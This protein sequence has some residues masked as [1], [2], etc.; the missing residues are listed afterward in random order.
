MRTGLLNSGHRISEVPP[1]AVLLNSDCCTSEI[2]LLMWGNPGF[3]RYSGEVLIMIRCLLFLLATILIAPAQA[4]ENV[5]RPNVLMIVTDDQGWNDIGYHNSEIITP[6]MDQLAKSGIRLER[7]YVYPTCSPT[8]CALLTGQCP[9]RFGILGPIAGKSKQAIPSDVLTLPRLLKKVNYETHISGKWHLGLRPEVGPTKYGFDSSYGYLHG[10]IDPIRHLYKFGDRTWHRNDKLME[11]EG[12]VT[13]LITNEAV[14]FIR[15]KRDKPFFLYVT[16]HSPHTPFVEEQKWID[17]Y[18]DKVK[19]P[20]RRLYLASITHVDH[21]LG[22]ILKALEETG[23]RKNTLIIFTSDNG[24]QKS[25]GKAK[26][27]YEG[28]FGPWP[29]LSDNTPLRGWKGD[30]YE[31]GIRVPA[32]V[33]WPAKL[34]PGVIHETIHATDWLPTLAKITGAKLPDDAKLD[35]VEAWEII[36]G[37]PAPENRVTYWKTGKQFAVR[38]GEWKLIV[39]KGK[40]ATPELFNVVKDPTEKKDLAKSEP[41]KLQRLRRILT[42]QQQLDR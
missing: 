32:I 12:H 10:Q 1:E 3:G 14:R 13:D 21:E 6:N 37:K 40:N 18:K 30:V 5:D 28:R 19:E 7:H 23:Q 42:E 20:S 35:G 11:E 22:R 36:T 24:G 16:H 34:K 33:N 39:G 25:G 29:V 31:G 26:N 27:Q 8:R 2:I 15:K 41:E 17:L 4:A 38:E 9:S